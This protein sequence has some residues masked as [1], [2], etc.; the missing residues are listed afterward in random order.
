MDFN[1]DYTHNKPKQKNQSL[2]NGNFDISK[3]KYNRKI[4][5]PIKHTFQILKLMGSTTVGCLI[6]LPGKTPHVTAIG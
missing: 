6:S 3:I 1:L 2:K 5:F 4:S